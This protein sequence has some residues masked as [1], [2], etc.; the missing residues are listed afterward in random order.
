VTSAATENWVGRFLGVFGDY[1]NSFFG[2]VKKT[3][4]L[5]N[6]KT[7]MDIGWNEGFWRK[8]AI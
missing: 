5:K 4:F 3:R 8:K 2:V 6:R 1:K 7:R